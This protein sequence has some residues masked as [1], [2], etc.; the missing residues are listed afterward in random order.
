MCCPKP[1]IKTGLT[2][3]KSWTAATSTKCRKRRHR[4]VSFLTCTDLCQLGWPDTARHEQGWV[5]Q[6]EHIDNVV[7]TLFSQLVIKLKQACQQWWTWLFYIDILCPLFP[8]ILLNSSN[9]L[10]SMVCTRRK[11]FFTM[12]WQIFSQLYNHPFGALFVCHA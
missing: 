1:V 10:F 9:T 12:L 8:L 3:S 5:G 4:K 11:S 6:H 7:I 2:R